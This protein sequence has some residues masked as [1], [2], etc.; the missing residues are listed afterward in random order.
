MKL[1]PLGSAFVL[2]ALRLAAEENAP[3]AAAE[4]VPVS[5]PP[6]LAVVISLDQFRAD[7]L[8]RFRP[9]FVAGGFRRLLEHGAVYTEARHRHALT[10]TAPGHSTLLSGV[11]PQVHGIIAN[12]WFDPVS[13]RMVG[14][15]ED[16]SAPLVG[17]TPLPAVRSPGGVL[18]TEETGSP[19]RLLA[20]TVGDQLKLRFGSRSKVISVANKDRAAILM[21]GQSSKTQSLDLKALLEMTTPKAYYLASWLPGL[22]SP[23]K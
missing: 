22:A 11:S 15:V 6:R 1:L 12:E 5:A 23:A 17:A 14:A 20:D 18:E 7:Y 21:G 2:L 3:V 4:A 16:P 9:Y 19:R 10:A 13:G 8:E